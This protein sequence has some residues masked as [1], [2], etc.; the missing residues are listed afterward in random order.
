MK[1]NSFE[2]AFQN[3]SLDPLGKLKVKVF[4]NSR[5]V[6]K[7]WPLFIFCVD[8]GAVLCMMMESMK[9]KSVVNALFRLQLKMGKI[10]KVSMNSSTNSIELKRMSDI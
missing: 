4:N 6:V 8:T 2:H 1:M 9:T 10:E 5:K 3:I 7:L